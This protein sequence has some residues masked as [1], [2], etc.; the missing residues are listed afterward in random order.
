MLA[1]G[2]LRSTG[3]STFD[4]NLGTEDI[5]KISQKKNIVLTLGPKKSRRLL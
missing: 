1:W 4:L 2:G 5:F 3:F